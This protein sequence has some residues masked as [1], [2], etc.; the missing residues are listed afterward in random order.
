MPGVGA[1]RVALFVGERV[2]LAVVGNPVDHR[3]LQGHRAQHG[4]RV[5]QP[6][7]R[8]KGAVG[9]EAVEAD[10][11]AN[12]GQHVHDGEDRQVAWPEEL[13][14]Q[15]YRGHDHPQ[16]GDHDGAD[17]HVALQPCHVSSTTLMM[18]LG[19]GHSQRLFSARSGLSSVALPGAPALD[20]PKKICHTTT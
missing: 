11:H 19:Y 8:L 9:E 2:V 1:V 13:V 6:R 14:P 20:A 16:E 15:Q 3:S 5:A 4:E 10:G 7:P 18:A 17:V 12:R